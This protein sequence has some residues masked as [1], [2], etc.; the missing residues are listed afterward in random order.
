MKKGVEIRDHH[1]LQTLLHLMIDTT[2]SLLRISITISTARW[3]DIF[4]W[5]C[6]ETENFHT[7]TFIFIYVTSHFALI[8]K[9]LAQKI[10]GLLCVI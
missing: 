3:S 1:D 9:G 8:L 7:L 2:G 4:E 6:I 10:M 5:D